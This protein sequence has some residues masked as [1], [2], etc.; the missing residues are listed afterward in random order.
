MT[1]IITDKDKHLLFP[2][3]ADT[4]A[5][6]WHGFKYITNTHTDGGALKHHFD[7]LKAVKMLCPDTKWKRTLEWCSGDG[8]LGMMFL[9]EKLTDHVTFMD[10]YDPALNG[11]RF[12]IKYNNLESCTEVIK[13]DKIANLKCEKVDLVIA[14]APS[15]R[16]C[17]LKRMYELGWLSR[18]TTPMTYKEAVKERDEKNPH[19]A[20]DWYWETHIEFFANIT[21]HLNP[22][23]DILLFENPRDFNPLFWEWGEMPENLELLQWVDHNQIKEL[24]THPQVILHFKYHG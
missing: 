21:K 2:E 14:N 3:N 7:Y 16:V 11:C 18:K 6:H 9:G 24:N 19:R 13:E 20:I 23:A 22:G 10:R 12:N 4:V 8:G 15:Q 1:P 17:S 5:V